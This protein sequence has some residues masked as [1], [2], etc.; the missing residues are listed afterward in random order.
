MEKVRKETISSDR[1]R[2]GQRQFYVKLDREEKGQWLK[3][4]Q[5]KTMNLVDQYDRKHGNPREAIECKFVT[6]AVQGKC[7]IEGLV[8]RIFEVLE[9]E[10]SDWLWW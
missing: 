10:D 6:N 5:V 2:Q 9:A 3:R 7:K 8:R 1:F 4:E